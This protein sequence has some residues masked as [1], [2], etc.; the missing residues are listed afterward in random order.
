MARRRG[1]LAAPWVCGPTGACTDVGAGGRRA[2]FCAIEK[3]T[4]EARGGRARSA[5]ACASDGATARAACRTLGVRP[6]R[7]LHPCWRGRP[8]ARFWTIWEPP[9][10]LRSH[11]PFRLENTC[12]SRVPTAPAVGTL[13]HLFSF[14][15][16]FLLRWAAPALACNL[17]AARFLPPTKRAAE[18]FATDPATATTGA[19]DGATVP[20]C[21]FI[22]GCALLLGLR[23]RSVVTRTQCMHTG[24]GPVLPGGRAMHE[25]RGSMVLQ[26]G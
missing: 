16:P 9:P 24:I 8:T 7:W 14:L 22:F 23:D 2:R 12:C 21:V 10:S 20:L 3:R 17:E 13:A 19:T 25:L 15:A 6:H 18:R 11:D 1:Q 26:Q 5:S 4:R